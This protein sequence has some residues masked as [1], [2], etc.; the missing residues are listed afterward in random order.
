MLDFFVKWY[1]LCPIYNV[2]LFACRWL[3]PT[4]SNV[5]EF[6]DIIFFK[7]NNPLFLDHIY[8]PFL[9]QFYCFSQLYMCLKG[10]TICLGILGA[11]EQRPRIFS[12]LYTRCLVIGLVALATMKQKSKEWAMIPY[13]LARE[14]EGNANLIKRT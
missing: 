12:S 13:S 7:Q 3:K 11:I 4:C 9:D 10:C 1:E 8:S 5:T 6:M 14:E 2:G